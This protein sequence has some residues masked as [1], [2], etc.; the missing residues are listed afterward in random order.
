MGDAREL[1]NPPAVADCE[2]ISSPTHAGPNWSRTFT[3]NPNSTQHWDVP[4]GCRIPG[5]EVF[6]ELGRGGM[7]VVY[8]ARQ[9]TLD[10]PVALKLLLAGAH[11]APAERQRFNA[12]ATATAQLRH[13]NIVQVFEAGEHDG[14]PF[15]TLEFVAGGSLA[16]RLNGTP[17][18]PRVAAELVET[19]ARAVQVAHQQGIVHRDLKPS[20][21]LITPDGVLKV[22]DFG[23]AKL[24]DADTEQTRTGAVLGTPS[25]MAPEQASGSGEIGPFTDVYA[26]GAI[27]YELLTGRAPFKGTS[28]QDTLEQVRSR[29]PVPPSRIQQV[30]R[31]LETICIKCLQ[32]QPHQR[33]PSAQALADELQRFLSGRPIQARRVGLVE[34]GWRWCRRNPAVAT[35]LVVTISLLA[36]LAVT[37]YIAYWT[38]SQALKKESEQ[39][40]RADEERAAAQAAEERAEKNFRAALVAFK[41][42][43]QVLSKLLGTDHP[44]TLSAQE[45]LAVTLAA[46]GKHDEAEP[47]YRDALQRRQRMFGPQHPLTQRARQGLIDSLVAQGKDPTVP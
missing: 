32:K 5:Y 33:Y 30:P 14:K 3:Q 42:Q 19:L 25:Y 46:N 7:G 28:V 45:N 39:R 47:L 44:D 43:Q 8:H 13:P 9:I 23:L 10:R 35:L 27:L 12:E 31:D 2:T 34:S 41:N 29:E 24:L 40:K 17:L 26:L 4:D 11:A 36:A 6:G 22:A 15:L 20:N 21:I 18:A 37:G 16:Q 1:G 38:T